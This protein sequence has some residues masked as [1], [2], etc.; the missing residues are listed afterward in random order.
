MFVGPVDG[1]GRHGR[2]GTG[3]KFFFSPNKWA[4]P[5]RQKGDLLGE[6]QA[7]ISFNAFAFLSY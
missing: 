2:S 5:S 4:F 1:H 7:Q 6:G 3:G